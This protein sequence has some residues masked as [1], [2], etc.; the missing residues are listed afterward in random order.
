MCS[1]WN[2]VAN[3]KVEDLGG[4]KPQRN[5]IEHS[6][7]VKRRILTVLFFAAINHLGQILEVLSYSNAICEDVSVAG[8]SD[9]FWAVTFDGYLVLISDPGRERVENG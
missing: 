1:F 7:P 3:P 8:H 6:W 5:F 9:S 4:G 2:N